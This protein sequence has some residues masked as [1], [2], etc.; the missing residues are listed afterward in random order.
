[1]SW[2]CKMVKNITHHWVCLGPFVLFSSLAEEVQRIFSQT[3][4]SQTASKWDETDPQFLATMFA[5]N[6][7]GHKKRFEIACDLKLYITHTCCKGLRVQMSSSR[8][9]IAHS[10]TGWSLSS[11]YMNT[12]RRIFMHTI[13]IYLPLLLTKHANSSV[14]FLNQSDWR[15]REGSFCQ[16][17]LPNRNILAHFWDINTKKYFLGHPPY[18]S[19]Y[20]CFLAKFCHACRKSIWSLIVWKKTARSSKNCTS[21]LRKRITR[22]ILEIK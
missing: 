1:M 15:W 8:I 3:T 20:S 10:F 9:K 17:S 4:L 21:W 5:N 16:E 14:Q 13:Y 6:S 19:L 11:K 22:C 12:H 18:A 7:E 2:W